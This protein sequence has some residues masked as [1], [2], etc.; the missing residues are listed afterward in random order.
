MRTAVWGPLAL[1]C[2]VERA[3]DLRAGGMIGPMEWG[4]SMSINTITI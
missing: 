2:C 3:D 4:S 1:I